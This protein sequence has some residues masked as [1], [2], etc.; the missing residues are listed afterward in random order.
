MLQCITYVPLQS[1]KVF[2]KPSSAT[3]S[4]TTHLMKKEK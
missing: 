4:I 2:Y 3:D 1:F